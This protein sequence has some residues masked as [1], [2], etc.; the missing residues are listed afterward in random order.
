MKLSAFELPTS[1]YAISESLGNNFSSIGC[2]YQYDDREKMTS[3]ITI[4]V[5]DGKTILQFIGI[6]KKM[7]KHAN[8]Q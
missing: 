5:N 1:F 6:D 4:I 2:T 7:R 8:N 3:N